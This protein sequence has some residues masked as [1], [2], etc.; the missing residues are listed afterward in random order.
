MFWISSA[1][2]SINFF[3][4]IF[5]HTYIHI[6]SF[7][8]YIHRLVML[9]NSNNLANIQI[10]KEIESS[11][12]V[13]VGSIYIKYYGASAPNIHVHYNLC[14]YIAVLWH[15]ISYMMWLPLCPL[16]PSLFFFLSIPENWQLFYKL[17][18]YLLVPYMWKCFNNKNNNININCYY[19]THF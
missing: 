11:L 9:I 5:P 1:W 15:C 12:W 18:S 17:L 14:I 10:M 3:L 4:Y 6:F 13:T 8:S 2:G 16:C 19:L 7:F